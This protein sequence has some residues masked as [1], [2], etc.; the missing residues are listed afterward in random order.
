M[1]VLVY[2]GPEALQKSVAHSLA[3]LR[4]LLL[5]QYT[6]QTITTQ[7]LTSEPWRTSCALFVLPQC[8]ERLQ[9]A[10][11]ATVKD[12]I[13]TG[14]SLLSF[15]S[16]AS[17]FERELSGAASLSKDLLLG[18]FDKPTG[19]Y[20]Y[21][22]YNRDADISEETTALQVT[23]GELVEGICGSRS[24]EFSG[25]DQDK[26]HKILA[27]F[28]EGNTTGAVAGLIRSIGLG[29]IAIWASNIEVPVTQEAARAVSNVSTAREVAE[30]EKRRLSLLKTT[31]LSLS[32]RLPSVEELPISR[33]L[34]QFLVSNPTSTNVISRIT[35]LIAAPSPGSQ[36]S[37]FKDDNDTFHFHSSVDGTSVL[38]NARENPF[39]SEN[40]SEWQPKHVILCP[41]SLPDK[42]QTP[43]FDLAAYY[44]SLSSARK[45]QGCRDV[46]DGWGIGE[47]LFYGE[48]VTSTQT[49]I[50]KNP[51][52]MS[53]LPSPLVSIASYQLAGRGRGSNVWLSPAGCLQFSVLLRVPLSSFPASKL[54]FVQYLF[55]LA[56]VEGCRDE[57]VLGKRGKYIRL[58]WPN[59]IY[60]VVD[61]DRKKIG[62]V[63]VNTSFTGGKVDILIGCGV[64][65]LNA[66]PI[67]S[68]K[69]LLPPDEQ[70]SLT[71]EN[72]VSNILA[73]FEKMWGLFVQERGSFDSF[74]DLYLER[75][76]HSDQLVTLTT[77]T[78]HQTVRIAGITPDH[79]LLRTMPERTGWSEDEGYIDLQPDGNSFDIM[80]GLIKHPSGEKEAFL[81]ACTCMMEA[82]ETTRTRLLDLPPETIIH[83]LT[84]LDF[85][86]II[87]ICRVNTVLRTCVNTSQSLQYRFAT[88]IA[89]ATDNRLCPLTIKER[90]ELLRRRENGWSRF[91]VD[92]RKSLP[93]LHQ[94]YGIYD[95]TSGIYLM[96]DVNQKALHYCKL[97]SK[98]E[99]T[100]SW[101]KIDLDK[102]LTVVDVGLSL[103][104]HDLVA[105][106]TTK[107]IPMDALEVEVHL[108]QF[109]TGMPHPLAKNPA[110]FVRK[111]YPPVASAIGIEVVGEYLALVTTP[112]ISELCA[113]FCVF[114]WKT[115]AVVLDYPVQHSTYCSIVFLSPRHILLANAF[116]GS[117]DVFVIPPREVHT[118]EGFDPDVDEPMVRLGLPM[119]HRGYSIRAIYGRA[120]PNPAPT[121]IPHS[122]LPFHPAPE[123][124]ISIFNM[125]I[126]SDGGHEWGDFSMFV[127]RSALLALCEEYMPPLTAWTEGGA[128]RQVQV[129]VS[130]DLWGPPRTRW[131]D[132]AVVPWWIT[133]S[134]GQRCVLSITPEA[135]EAGA[136]PFVTILDFNPIAVR[137]VL[138][139][140][141]GKAQKELEGVSIVYTHASRMGHRVFVEP[142]ESTLP[143][144]SIARHIVSEKDF[145]F[146]G[147]L[148]DEERLLG[149]VTDDEGR[150]RR[151]EIF[152]TGDDRH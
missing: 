107:Q 79:G 36:L 144:V 38:K 48:V 151:I 87:S 111:A 25:F 121:G 26:G 100:L 82:I 83:I 69:Q 96:G 8:R 112:N 57:S 66:A 15:G 109:S 17:R 150:V 68:L 27:R 43:L 31:L 1:N 29:K 108:L 86:D 88:Q 85:A 45:D 34:P 52:L 149:L 65:V 130:W 76:L 139:E 132:A 140:Y 22:T 135:L 5:P 147:V 59:D 115:G 124:A 6:V 12:Y 94:P 39:P 7:K 141:A 92:F 62:G 131:I 14:G 61:G 81:H 120:E 28:P 9:P 51:R 84:F 129:C 64:N 56:V 90:F 118:A 127:H 24:H 123:D 72:T 104:E 23:D 75:W 114:E 19:T 148:M 146:D 63:L 54:V 37:V 152:H 49:L 73:R 113:R 97:P 13:E 30:G 41:D 42:S 89:G 110:L 125:H 78:P 91:K 137:R 18:L 35:D 20:V 55:A 133:T 128:D 102:D 101:Q 143:Y 77:V 126:R 103:Y 11:S 99:D 47:A 138:A 134:T 21:L 50:D 32:L 117:L 80:A 116:P 44:Q 71:L 74:M 4:S 70:R 122:T 53:R 40:P 98:R 67:F 119:I 2:A 16:G 136:P 145:E 3:T 105:V 33:P 10:S 106:V 95:L 58:K 60:A 46:P 93:I 142:V